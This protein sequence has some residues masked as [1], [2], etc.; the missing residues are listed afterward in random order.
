MVQAV[1]LW[2]LEQARE[3]M[4]ASVVAGKRDMGESLQLTVKEVQRTSRLH[5]FSFSIPASD[6][7]ASPVFHQA[8]HSHAPAATPNPPVP[9]PLKSCDG[10]PCNRQPLHEASM[11]HRARLTPKDGAGNDRSIVEPSCSSFQGTSC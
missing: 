10:A 1:V 7:Q 4:Q 11:L 5:S 2:M 6:R 9:V 8:F 3:E